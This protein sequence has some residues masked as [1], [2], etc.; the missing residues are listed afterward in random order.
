MTEDGTRTFGSSR[1][2]EQISFALRRAQDER[3]VTFK[4][5][6]IPFVLS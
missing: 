5:N 6:H 2:D 4:Q 1:A 3:G